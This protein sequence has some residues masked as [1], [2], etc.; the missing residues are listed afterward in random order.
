[1][2]VKSNRFKSGTAGLMIAVIL[3]GCSGSKQLKEELPVVEFR[4]EPGK[5]FILVDKKPFATYVYEDSVTTRPYFEN[6]MTPCGIRATRN[7]PVLAGDPK[8]HSSWHPG[9]WLSYADLNGIDYW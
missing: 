4:Q 5:L 8:D 3:A 6:V 2:K 7:H 1:M 9:I